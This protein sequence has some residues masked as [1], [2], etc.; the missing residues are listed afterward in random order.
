[1]S[2]KCRK[3]F[4]PVWKK[5][6]SIRIKSDNAERDKKYVSCLCLVCPACIP[7][8]YQKYVF[9]RVCQVLKMPTLSRVGAISICLTDVLNLIDVVGL[10]PVSY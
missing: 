1:M 6:S 10:L 7:E 2:C 5:V 4:D 3:R 9:V 8:H